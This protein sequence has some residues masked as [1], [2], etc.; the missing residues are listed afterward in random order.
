MRKNSER[1]KME[2]DVG[3]TFL[4]IVVDRKARSQKSLSKPRENTIRIKYMVTF[5]Y[6]SIKMMKPSCQTSTTLEFTRSKYQIGK[7]IRITVMKIS[8]E[9]TQ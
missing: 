9:K 5:I 6:F 4:K 8:R 1:Q 7:L 2:I 3:F